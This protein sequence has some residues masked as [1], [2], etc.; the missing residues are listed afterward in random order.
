M[1]QKAG[2]QRFI[3]IISDF[4]GKQLTKAAS[5]SLNRLSRRTSCRL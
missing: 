2:F 3:I 1:T 4:P 5:G